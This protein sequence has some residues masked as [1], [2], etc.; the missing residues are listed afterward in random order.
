VV[1]RF[2][3]DVLQALVRGDADV[4]LEDVDPPI[5]LDRCGRQLLTALAMRDIAGER[6]SRAAFGED[7]LHRL[8]GPSHDLIGAHDRC[9]LACEE[10]RRGLAVADARTPRA[11]AYDHRNLTGQPTAHDVHA[12]PSRQS[13]SAGAFAACPSLSCREVDDG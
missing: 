10:N 7:R 4:V 13:A 8:V 5:A 6:R 9:A 12:L 1:P 11:G 2:F 3:G